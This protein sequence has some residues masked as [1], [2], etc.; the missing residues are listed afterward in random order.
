MIRIGGPLRVALVM[1][2]LSLVSA[3]PRLADA[4]VTS[5]P[6]GTPTVRF[7]GLGTPWN[8]WSAISVCNTTFGYLYGNGSSPGNY[9]TGSTNA[10]CGE[11][12]EDSE[13]IG[14]CLCT[15]EKNDGTP[16]SREINERCD[17][18]GG[19]GDMTL[20][21]PNLCASGYEYDE[22]S[23]TG[24]TYVQTGN[25]MGDACKLACPAGQI[26]DPNSPEGCVEVCP[27]GGERIE[28]YGP[29]SAASQ[30]DL[31]ITANTDCVSGCSWE[32]GAAQVVQLSTGTVCGTFNG[33]ET[34]TGLPSTFELVVRYD[35]V[36]AECSNPPNPVPDCIGC[37]VTS[38]W[39][40]PAIQDPETGTPNP[41]PKTETT[42]ET[43]QEVD[44]GDGTTTS[45]RTTIYPDASERVETTTCDAAGNCSSTVTAGE[46]DATGDDDD[47]PDS[48][49]SGLGS[50][51]VAPTCQ[52][53]AAQCAQVQLAWET[54]CAL[55]EDPGTDLA[56]EAAE[57]P[58][59][60]S[61][62]AV[63]G[64]V[65]ASG[66]ADFSDIHAPACIPDPT[67]EA[68]GETYAV[69]AVPICDVSEMVGVMN[70]LIAPF[71][72]MLVV[73]RG[74]S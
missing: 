46:G 18:A 72:Y 62:L 63:G 27:A 1:V 54:A 9:N 36:G 55:T 3:V 32:P 23:G 57:L 20:V 70:L 14:D 47:T 10:S 12:F 2:L 41:D 4:Q 11:I 22:L 31:N 26:P 61:S 60:A 68:F 69:S 48:S 45:T 17:P 5:P 43:T 30:S 15:G 19:C 34:C 50:C 44:N 52:G 56:T 7:G 65:D 74:W 73:I 58:A 6:N 42:T 13:G 67:F 59:D 29:Y 8:E 25:L 16:L 37:S 71:L 51:D 28:R 38:P 33:E 49:V 53:D 35:A 66:L 40:D 64:D 21:T 39:P 24:S